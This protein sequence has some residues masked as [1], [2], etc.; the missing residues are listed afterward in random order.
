[1]EFSFIDADGITQTINSESVGNKVFHVDCMVALRATPDKFYDLCICDPPY[2][3][4]I[5]NASQG[6]WG[7]SRLSR[8]NWDKQIPPQEYFDELIRVS[9]NQIISG[10]NYF[11]SIWPTRGFVVWD[12]GNGFRGRDFAEAELIWTSYDR[13]ARVFNY[14]PLARGD[15]R[16]KIH[17]TQKPI[18]LYDWLIVNYAKDCKNILDTHVGSGSSR[19]AASKADL[20]FVGFEIDTEYWQ[21]QENRFARFLAQGRLF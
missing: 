9:K 11:P 18:P 20:G 8:K 3:I 6:M 12:K 16:G 5:G 1:M 21:A 15:Y 2:G 13:N 7:C 4:D 19:I 14:D 10:G 17:P